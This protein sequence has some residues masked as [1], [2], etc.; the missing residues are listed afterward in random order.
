MTPS[1][2]RYV[3]LAYVTGA[4]TAAT[5]GSISAFLVK[6]SSGKTQYPTTIPAI[7]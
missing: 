6:N 7:A 3:Q 4:T 1:L 2:L 5:L